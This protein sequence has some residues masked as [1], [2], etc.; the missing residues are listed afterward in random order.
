MN[1][2][3]NIEN[4]MVLVFLQDF[5]WKHVKFLLSKP[6]VNEI[7][8]YYFGKFTCEINIANIAEKIK[9][10]NPVFYKY[11]KKYSDFS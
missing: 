6:S 9:M 3:S 1:K 7:W 10:L 4:S 8:E 2:H 11:W 5:H